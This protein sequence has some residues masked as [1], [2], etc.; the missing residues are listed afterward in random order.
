MRRLGRVEDHGTDVVEE[1]EDECA[2]YAAFPPP[3]FVCYGAGLWAT[4]S[5]FWNA[6]HTYRNIMPADLLYLLMHGCADADVFL[7]CSNEYWPSEVNW[8]LFDGKGHYFADERTDD[9]F[10]CRGGAVLRVA[11]VWRHRH[12]V[13]PIAGADPWESIRPREW[14]AIVGEP[15]TS[16][17]IDALDDLPR[18]INGG[19]CV[20]E[21]ELVY[22]VFKFFL[23]RHPLRRDHPF[24]NLVSVVVRPRP[25]A[26]MDPESANCR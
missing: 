25:P 12:R 14:L 13:E 21:D 4:R 24:W 16:A 3:L 1:F 19:G 17:M 6:A 20:E 26:P 10:R 15:S 22:Y 7:R 11:Q 2:T 9:L 8:I 23:M 18:F 5:V